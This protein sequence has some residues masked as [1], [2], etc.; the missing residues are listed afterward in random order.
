MA[1]LKIKNQS[2]YARA[3]WFFSLSN[4]NMPLT[5]TDDNTQRVKRTENSCFQST[6]KGEGIKKFF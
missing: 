1:N 2:A 6:E 3:D 4:E 5:H